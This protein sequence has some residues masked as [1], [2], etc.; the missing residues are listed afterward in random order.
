MKEGNLKLHTLMTQDTPI[1]LDGPKKNINWQ[2][3]SCIHCLRLNHGCK[4]YADI[5][6]DIWNTEKRCPHAEYTSKEQEDKVNSLFKLYCP[7]I[8]RRAKF[9]R[10]SEDERC[11]TGLGQRKKNCRSF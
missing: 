8:R 9:R 10:K 6:L 7:P 1:L 4:K 5:P 2:C 11:Q 3:L